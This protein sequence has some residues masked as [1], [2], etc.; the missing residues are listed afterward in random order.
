MNARV[1][2]YFY[3][4]VKTVERHKSLA[5]EA[6]ADL[7]RDIAQRKDEILKHANGF[8]TKTLK[9]EIMGVEC[10]IQCELSFTYHPEEP[11]AWDYP[12]YPAEAELL[13]VKCG[14]TELIDLLTDVRRDIEAEICR[15]AKCREEE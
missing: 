14:E 2:P 5:E 3:R 4:A 11:R 1:T 12:G 13:S 10:E 15:G 7:A 8:I 9:L 6:S